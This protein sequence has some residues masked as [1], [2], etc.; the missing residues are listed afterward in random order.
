MPA[1]SAA[2]PSYNHSLKRRFQVLLPTLFT[3]GRMVCGFIAAV[4]MFVG[5]RAIGTPEA[6]TAGLAAFDAAAKAIGFAILFDALDGKLARLVRSD[7]QFGLELDSLADSTTFGLATSLLIFSWGV[8]TIHEGVRT[9][10]SERLYVAGGI[11][12]CAFMVCGAGR[13]AR[14]NLGAGNG[15]SSHSDGLSTPSAAGVIA[16]VVHFVKAPITRFD[17]AVEWLALVAV[18][19]LLMISRLRYDPLAVLPDL[20]RKPA[21]AIPLGC[22][23]VWAIWTYSEPV[24]L[25]IAVGNCVSGPL[26]LVVS[27]LRGRPD[28]AQ[29]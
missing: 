23:L 12:A 15:H 10:A 1:N 28:L 4:S 27:R 22:L 8:A 14:F 16:A 9:S 26:T 2:K 3:A 7:S 29:I 5:M 21:F 17:G 25:V 20:L 18:L 24:L 13:L 11:I 6:S 19:S